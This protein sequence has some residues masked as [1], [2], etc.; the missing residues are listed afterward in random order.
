MRTKVFNDAIGSLQTMWDKAFNSSTPGPSCRPAIGLDA[1]DADL[2]GD[3]KAELAVGLKN[4]SNDIAAFAD[5]FDTSATST[6]W[7]K[8]GDRT[9]VAPCGT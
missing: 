4:A 8:D 9:S 6:D 5:P 2:D 1:I 3:R 7:Y